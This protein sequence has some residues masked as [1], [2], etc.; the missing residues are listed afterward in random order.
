MSGRTEYVSVGGLR[1]DGRR[2]G[3]IR[4]IRCNMGLF[5]HVDGSA[6]LEQGGTKVFAVVYGPREVKFRRDQLHD[7]A[8]INCDFSVAPFSTGERKVRR[9]T[10]SKSVENGLAIKRTFEA[11]ILTNLYPRT[12]ID[13]FIQI[14]QADGGT[15][16]AAI[17]AA[18]LALID[19]GVA[20]KDFVVACSAGFLGQTALTDLNYV[21]ESAKGPVIPIALFPASDGVSMLQ[22]SSKMPLE[23]LEEVMGQAVAGCHQLHAVLQNEVKEHTL[24][25]VNARGDTTS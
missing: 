20:M 4:R 9:A 21:E 1:I 15:L 6:Y 17:N 11:A 22:M 13:I 14:V 25:L 18:N 8:L 12:Q 5:G 19:A 10:D 16:S 7:R 2:P 24:R 3:E 23:L